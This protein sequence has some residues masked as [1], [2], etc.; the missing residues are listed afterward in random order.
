MTKSIINKIEREYQWQV[1]DLED[2]R[3]T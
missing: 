1:K 3:K 2:A